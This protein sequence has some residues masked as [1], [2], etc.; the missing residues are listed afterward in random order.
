MVPARHRVFTAA[1]ST[2]E[3]WNRIYGA[4]L[5]KIGTGAIVVLLG[6]RGR[7]KTQMATCLIAESRFN[8]KS[9][10][11]VKAID[12]FLKI[13]SS[14]RS[15]EYSERDVVKEYCAPQLLVIDA[16]EN[17]SE[18]AF[19]NQ[20]LN[21]IIDRRYDDLND[22]IL[23]TNQ[24]PGPFATSVGPSIM[25]RIEETGGLVVCDWDSFRTEKARAK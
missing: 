7:G 23:I 2:N 4:L 14:Y 5:P 1:M 25:S 24:E 8:A 9:A 10:L 20:T 16:I 17:R 18:S 6:G 12:V 3:R 21:H 11:Y 22:T 13:R 15:D 19:E